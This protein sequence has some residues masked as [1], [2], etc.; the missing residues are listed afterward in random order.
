MSEE[1]QIP[2]DVVVVEPE[3]EAWLVPNSPNPKAEV[4]R[5][6]REEGKEY[7]TYLTKAAE[8]VDLQR[9]L[10]QDSNFKKFH[11]LLIDHIQNP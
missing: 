2:C 3:I 6:S 7:M 1:I 8:Q 4:R 11:G 9:L 5:R 10:A